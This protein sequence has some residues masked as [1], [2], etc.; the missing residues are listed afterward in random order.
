MAR[1]TTVSNENERILGESVVYSGEVSTKLF[2]P[3]GYGTARYSNGDEFCGIF[4][5]GDPVAGTYTFANGSF[6]KIRYEYNFGRTKYKKYYVTS[7]GYGYRGFRHQTHDDLSNGY[8]E[9]EEKNG[10]R[11]GMGTYV[12]NS[13]ERYTGGW[14][15]NKKHGV[16]MYTYSDGDYDWSIWDE[17]TEVCVLSRYRKQSQEASKSTCYGRDDDYDSGN[18]WVEDTNCTTD[19]LFDRALHEINYGSAEDALS[20]L[21]SLR[22]FCDADDYY[23]EDEMG[24]RIN[25]DEQIEETESLI[26]E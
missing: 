10:M 21:K 4:E 12:W 15:N 14:H 20:A 8:Y 11:H 17:G 13:G 16:G 7:H 23:F 1:R 26:D 25:I 9:G 3:D 18:A 19:D 24:H 22:S 6:C 2:K 5:K